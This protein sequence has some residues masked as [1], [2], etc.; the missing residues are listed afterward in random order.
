MTLTDRQKRYAAARA[1]GMG[2]SQAAREAGYAPDS[3]KNAAAKL[4]KHDGV[5]AAIAAAKASQPGEDP[6]RSLEYQT[7][8]AYLSAVVAGIARPDPIRVSAARALISYQVPRQRRPLKAAV[9]PTQQEA[10]SKTAEERDAAADWAAKV[11][12]VKAKL[13]FVD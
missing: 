1:E 4:E 5:Q 6:V 13:G 9:T 10:R 7:A 11:Q 8:E 12:A 2:P 3:A